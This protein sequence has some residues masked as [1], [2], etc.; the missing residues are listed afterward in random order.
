MLTAFLRV[1]G[2]IAAVLALT[3]VDFRVVHANSATAGFTYLVLILALATRFGFRES[4]TA[5][6]VSVLTYN[7]FFLP[8]V[9]TFTIADPQNWV[10]LLAFLIT[11]IT[12]SQ[13]SSSAGKREEEAR[14]R[15]EELQ[16][17]YDFSR[18]LILGEE[19][20]GLAQQI[21]KQVVG[22]LGAEVAWF[23]DCSTELTSRVDGV[24]PVFNRSLMAQVA[25]TG[26]MWRHPE[27]N[28][29]IIPVRLGGASLGSLGI[30]GDTVPSE[31]ALQAIAQLVAI[32]MERERAQRI[33]S[34]V[35]ATRENEQLKS[36][37][38]D[39]LAHEF[40]TPLTSVKAATTTFLSSPDLNALEQR[41]L[42]TIVNEEA[43]RMN[44]LVSDSIELARIG[45]TPLTLHKDV[46]APEELVRGAVNELRGLLDGRDLKVELSADL[47]AVLA[48]RTLSELALRQIL[49]NALKYSPARSEV[50][51][52]ARQEE[53]FVIVSVC[54]S[55]PGIRK[56]DQSKIFEKFYRGADVRSRVPG[57]GMGLNI[58]RE[59]I[60]AQGG[61]IVVESEVG[62][63]A[64]FSLTFPIA[65]VLVKAAVHGAAE[66]AE[67]A[68]QSMA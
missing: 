27:R 19:D 61:R 23:Y 40:K 7:F 50:R 29:V 3:A 21:V 58:S 43:D 53:N 35:E 55:G 46:V 54:D 13:L 26:R 37:L 44:R 2:V 32:A 52:E 8:P 67:S 30:A 47:P 28:A 42:L 31:V 62:Q 33:A 64:R 5:S 17:M 57:A 68:R 25:E 24:E 14:A 56:V 9:G 63:G 65:G 11:A 41:E 48:D 18:G 66:A 6:L 1:A 34:R 60:E 12:A 20:Y 4:I 51:V 36:T 10:A 39:A 38:L 22:S 16:R 49:N 59:I 15:Q 45:T